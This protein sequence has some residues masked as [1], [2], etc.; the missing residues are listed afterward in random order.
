MFTR[1]LTLAAKD[2][3]QVLSGGNG[4][5][6]AVLLGLLLVF[7]FSLSSEPGE[8]IAP[9]SAAA[10]FWIASC[11]SLVL[12]FT[13]LYR[14]EEE[15]ETRMALIM[16]PMP[17][18][19]VWLGKLLGGL[20]LLVMAQVCFIPA[21]IVFLAQET[22]TSA[23][24][25]FALIGGVDAGLVILGSLLGAVSQGNDTRDSLLSIILFPLLLPLLLGGV[26][27]GGVLLQ[28]ASLAGVTD[29]FGII[30]AF[31]VIFAGAAMLLFPHVYGPE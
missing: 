7:I 23:V 10:I 12:I 30:G 6:Q 19:T 1:G 25:L 16:T 21:I 18:Q 11:F 28:G 2:L 5:F 20:A 9:Q 3:R 8:R 13:M 4:L 27:V 14:L 29:W 22:L 26:K 31:D 15:N 24:G 17:I